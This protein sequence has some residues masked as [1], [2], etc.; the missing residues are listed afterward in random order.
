MC[1]VI[2]IKLRFFIRIH[3]RLFSFKVGLVHQER[4]NS[5]GHNV[6]A[7]SSKQL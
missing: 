4:N 6:A 7:R 5:N 3:I 2:I 1:I